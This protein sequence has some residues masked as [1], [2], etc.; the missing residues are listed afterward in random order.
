[1]SDDVAKRDKRLLPPVYLLLAIILMLLLHF[2]LPV[3]RWHWWPW[4]LIGAVAMLLG[5]AINVVAD[6]QFKRHGTT[7]KPFQRSSALVTD[8][9]FRVSRNPMYVGMVCGLIGLGVFLASLTPFG[10]IPLFVWWLTGTFIVPEEHDLAEQFGQ[11]Y[12]PYTTRVR[13]WL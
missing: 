9:V 2:F 6:N 7:V 13:R 5:V 12:R 11:T 1:M 8:G 3:K 10:V 4:N